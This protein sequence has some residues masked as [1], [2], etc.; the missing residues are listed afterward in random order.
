MLYIE[1]ESPS[2]AKHVRDKELPRCTKSKT[3]SE[4]PSRVIPNTEIADPNLAQLR[5]DKVDPMPT[6]SKTDNE[7]P[8]RFRP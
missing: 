6:K 1:I 7:E 4:L 2:L 3:E 8:N 5:R